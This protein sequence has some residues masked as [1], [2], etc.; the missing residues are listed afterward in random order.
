MRIDAERSPVMACL[1]RNRLW[2][3]IW[4]TMALV[5]IFQGAYLGIQQSNIR[6]LQKSDDRAVR[7]IVVT[8][9]QIEGRLVATRLLTPA[10]AQSVFG[11][12]PQEGVH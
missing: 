8:V 11:N 2:V 1:Y 10:Q 7:A 6:A 12:I 9:T 5:L 3:I 4:A